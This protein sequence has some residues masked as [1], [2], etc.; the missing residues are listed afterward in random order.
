MTKW[1]AFLAGLVLAVA[2]AAAGCAAPT[3]PIPPPTALVSAPD[4]S[5]RVTVTGRADPAAYVFLLNNDTDQGV[6]GHAATDGS[7]SLR[8]MAASGNELWVWQELNS[9][10][11]QQNI[12]TVP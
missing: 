11:S 3:L 4:A 10:P 12:Q 1:R 5:G 2:V 6:I 8:V 7:F 9:Q